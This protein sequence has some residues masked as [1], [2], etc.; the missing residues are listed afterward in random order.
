MTVRRFFVPRDRIAGELAHLSAQESHHLCRVLRLGAGAQVQVFDDAGRRFTARVATA[1]ETGATLR[2]V[3]QV[4]AAPASAGVI[5]GLA[6]SKNRIFEEVLEKA[7]EL[8]AARVQPLTA[9]RSTGRYRPQRWEKIVIAACK[10]SGRDQVP[11]VPAPLPLADYLA[12]VPEPRRRIWLAPQPEAPPLRA[13]GSG[14]EG[15]PWDVA[16]GPEGGWTPEETAAATAAGFQVARLG[17]GLPTLRVETAAVAALAILA[18]AREAPPPEDP[19][20][21]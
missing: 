5:L 16:I 12:P 20:C 2:L 6:L 15:A 1:R 4:A 14:P 9:A 10:Q 8:G 11:P 3:E 17:L 7:V 13:L 19:P 21:S 18:T